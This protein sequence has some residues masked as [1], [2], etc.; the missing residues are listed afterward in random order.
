MSSRELR[1]NVIISPICLIPR[2][3]L[4]PVEQTFASR[5]VLGT[6]H[7]CQRHRFITYGGIRHVR[8]K[9]EEHA[10]PVHPNQRPPVLSKKLLYS[11][12]SDYYWHIKPVKLK[13][14]RPR[15]KALEA[16]QFSRDETRKVRIELNVPA[17]HIEVS[18]INSSKE[19]A[20]IK[21]FRQVDTFASFGTRFQYE[22]HCPENDALAIIYGASEENT[23]LRTSL[24]AVFR[25]WIEGDVRELEGPRVP[26]FKEDTLVV[27]WL[28]GCGRYTQL[29]SPDTSQPNC[30]E[31]ADVA[32][33]RGLQLQS[34]GPNKKQ[35]TWQCQLSVF[36]DDL[37]AEGLRTTGYSSNREESAEAVARKM[38]KMLRD[39]ETIDTNIERPPSPRDIAL[40]NTSSLADTQ[41]LLFDHRAQYFL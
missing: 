37:G 11:S 36:G 22:Q 31:L 28:E 20:M 14:D 21:R 25:K 27:R 32:N 29:L 4:D 6:L 8:P 39:C 24:Q 17:E 19:L 18:S 9:T 1:N 41:S 34:T 35:H 12:D 7:N 13:D 5:T 16:K 26:R 3:I 23:E 38:L 2:S 33:A 40:R 15:I 30:E 10:H